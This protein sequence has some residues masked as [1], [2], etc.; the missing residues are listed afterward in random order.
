MKPPGMWSRVT[1]YLPS[2]P[3]TTSITSAVDPSDEYDTEITEI[4]IPGI[5]W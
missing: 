3:C 5:Y 2:P 4:N 1:S